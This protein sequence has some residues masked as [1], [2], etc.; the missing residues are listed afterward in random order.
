[1]ITLSLLTLLLLPYSHSLSFFTNLTDMVVSINL[2]VE[3]SVFITHSSPISL[4]WTHNAYT[5]A[6]TP[7]SIACTPVISG[8]EFTVASTTGLSLFKMKI[9]AVNASHAGNV[10]A[11]ATRFSDSNVI[12]SRAI[13]VVND[14]LDFLIA[15]E[16]RTT[17]VGESVEFICIGNKGGGNYAWRKNGTIL[18]PNSNSRFVFRP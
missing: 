7:P 18:S 5:F 3:F 8:Y 16:N 11:E 15:P 4:T 6:C 13:L 14:V 12:T 10:S 17:L 1:M 2:P 9:A